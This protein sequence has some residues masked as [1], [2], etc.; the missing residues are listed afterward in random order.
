MCLSFTLLLLP[1]P[2]SQG[3]LLHSLLLAPF[4][5][6]AQGGNVT[7]LFC[8]AFLYEMDEDKM[9]D[10]VVPPLS[11][12]M[13]LLNL[14]T[15][16]DLLN[17]SWFSGLTVLGSPLANSPDLPCSAHASATAHLDKEKPL[18]FLNN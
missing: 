16:L 18:P 10:L 8:L 5:Q 4:T 12:S 2:L 11:N 1:L 6:P 13:P 14:E 9:E 17:P 3:L 7:L 15:A